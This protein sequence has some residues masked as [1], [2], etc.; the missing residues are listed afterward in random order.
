M[1]RTLI[2]AQPQR[3]G[4]WQMMYRDTE[5]RISTWLEFVYWRAWE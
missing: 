2:Y 3:D 4:V 5:C 1:K